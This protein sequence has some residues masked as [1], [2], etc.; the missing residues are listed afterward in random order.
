VLS[1]GHYDLIDFSITVGHETGTPE[2]GAK[3]RTWMKHLSTFVR[4]FDFV[5]AEPSRAWVGEVPREVFVASLARAGEDYVAYFADARERRD[6]QAGMPIT[7]KLAMQLPAG[8][9]VGRFYSP[10]SG[11]YSAEFAL[12]GGA[13]AAN[14][15]V[16]AFVH[17]IVLRASAR[18]RN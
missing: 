18:G 5:H 17:D 13:E 9:Y 7:I 4:S 16:T 2:S 8:D 14:V 3:L 11:A 1:G 12:H 15:Q 6:D 10:V